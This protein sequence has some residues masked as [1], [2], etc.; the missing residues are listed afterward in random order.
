MNDTAKVTRL[1]VIDDLGRALTCQT[2]RV[3][4]SYQDDGRTLK[5][6]LKG[7]ASTRQLLEPK[8]GQ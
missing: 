2:C 7:R 6:F 8:E 3:D 1:E 5:V 4:L